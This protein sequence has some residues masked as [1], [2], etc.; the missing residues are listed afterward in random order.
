MGC[1]QS[2]PKSN[3]RSR[4]NYVEAVRETTVKALIDPEHEFY[5][6]GDNKG[7]V[8]DSGHGN[9][10]PNDN[11][12]YD[13]NESISSR[14]HAS[15]DDSNLGDSAI[16]EHASSEAGSEGC[17]DRPSSPE[18]AVSPNPMSP[19]RGAVPI[20]ED[21]GRI[22]KALTPSPPPQ[23]VVQPTLTA[24]PQVTRASSGPRVKSRL[25]E[26]STARSQYMMLQ[27][28]S[29]WRVD[30][31]RSKYE[32]T[33][34]KLAEAGN[35]SSLILTEN[36]RLKTRL[37][38]LERAIAIVE[39]V[40]KQSVS[41]STVDILPTVSSASTPRVTVP[42]KL[43]EFMTPPSRAVELPEEFMTP[44][45]APRYEPEPVNKRNWETYLRPSAVS[46][47]PPFVSNSKKDPP[48]VGR[49][50]KLKAIT[51]DLYKLSESLAVVDLKHK[52]AAG[53]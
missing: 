11:K 37:Q 6:C 18:L 47:T 23:Q 25:A 2:I 21:A 30:V 52:K 1:F 4:R 38:E 26:L 14:K 48:T 27:V 50:E 39:S 41:T 51:E 8:E 29:V 36:A 12:F 32:E 19:E 5:D 9:V 31:L 42:P 3:A 49:K 45:S 34:S 13:A 46:V 53:S 24:A 15:S 17:S 7:V 33:L 35:A 43:E 16:A 10:A 40:P 20:R 28:F 44:D 22:V